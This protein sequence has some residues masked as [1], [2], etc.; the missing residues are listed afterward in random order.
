MG[1]IMITCPSTGH[2]VSTGIE[3]LDVDQLPPVIA[4][5]FCS[6][7]GRVHEWTKHESWLAEGGKHYRKVAAG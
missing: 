2:E 7:C 5:M 6:E 1:I 3:M 4:T